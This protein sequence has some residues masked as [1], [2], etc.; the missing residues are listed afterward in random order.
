MNGS[1]TEFKTD[2]IIVDT[3]SGLWIILFCCVE[4]I[5]NL[6]GSMIVLSNG[7]MFEKGLSQSPRIRNYVG[8]HVDIIV[9]YG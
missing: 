7:F 5:F 4:D 3:D 9:N 1:H 2:Y 6:C 8:R